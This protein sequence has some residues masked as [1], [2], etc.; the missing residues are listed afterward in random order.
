[1]AQ[2]DVGGHGRPG[3]GT[4][5]CKPAH[6]RG[7][8]DGIGGKKHR[9][10]RNEKEE[11]PDETG[12]RFASLPSQEIGAGLEMIK[13]G[14]EGAGGE[15]ADAIGLG[16]TLTFGTGFGGVWISHACG[17]SVSGDR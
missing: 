10:A 12:F 6:Q 3:Q 11:A 14:G 17:F 4:T 9:R 13:K 16:S 1:M 15:G 2:R 8:A 7:D 5:L